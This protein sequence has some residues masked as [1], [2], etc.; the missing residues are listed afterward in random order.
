MATVS[1]R[2]RP[3]QGAI[4][5]ALALAGAGA[6]G[7]SGAD[8]SWSGLKGGLRAAVERDPLDALA[9]TVLG[10]AFLFWLAERDA[11]PRCRSYFD[12]LVFVSTNLSVGYT[13]IFAKTKAGEAIASAIMTVGPAMAAAALAPPGGRREPSAEVVAVGNAIATK[14]DAILVELRAGR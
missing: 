12:A 2:V 14:L 10:G 7:E 11:N 3:H 4:L 6:L 1:G 13:D 5:G 8:L 9:V